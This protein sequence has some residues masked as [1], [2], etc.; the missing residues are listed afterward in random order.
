MERCRL[1]LF[2]LDLAGTDGRSPI[3]DYLHLQKEL[4]DYDEELLQKDF[5]IV[6]NKI[7]EDVGQS[8]LDA[9]RQR[10]PELTIFPISAI[11]ESGLSELKAHLLAHFS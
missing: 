11:L 6:G 7:D 1:I 5:I 9:F 4:K 8:N 3:E 2:L 10:F